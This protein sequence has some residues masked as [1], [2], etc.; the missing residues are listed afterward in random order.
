MIALTSFIT[1][2][3]PN[4][5][6]L[7]LSLIAAGVTGTCVSLSETSPSLTETALS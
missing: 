7:S 6:G 2:R 1:A 3:S 4:E 5:P